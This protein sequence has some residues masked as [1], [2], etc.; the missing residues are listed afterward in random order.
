MSRATLP[1]ILF[2]ILQNP[3]NYDIVCWCNDGKSFMIKDKSLFISLLQNEG[4]KSSDYDSTRRLLLYLKFQRSKTTIG[5][6]L[7]DTFT[8]SLFHNEASIEE[9]SF[10]KCKSRNKKFKDIEVANILLTFA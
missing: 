6:E 9:I 4:R 3:E 7:Y 10:I 2:K 5:F 8:H 1:I